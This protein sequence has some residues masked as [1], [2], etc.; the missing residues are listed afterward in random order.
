MRAVIIW[1]PGGKTTAAWQQFTKNFVTS[2]SAPPWVDGIKVYHFRHGHHAL[3]EDAKQMGIDLNISAYSSVGFPS[4]L[5]GEMFLHIYR[6]FDLVIVFSKS[7]D[8]RRRDAALQRIVNSFASAIP[9]L[10]EVKGESWT[11][12]L[13]YYNYSCVFRNREE[14]CTLLENSKQADFSNRCVEQAMDIVKDF[15]PAMIVQKYLE[16]FQDIEIRAQ[17]GQSARLI[18]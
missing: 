5:I 12:F 4:E 13:T 6:Q 1:E 7:H 11:H 14:L 16:M 18:T 15:S 3:E 10:V 17:H 2:G 8:E 9:V